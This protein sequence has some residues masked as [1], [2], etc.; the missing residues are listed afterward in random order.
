MRETLTGW[1]EGARENA[2]MVIVLGAVLAIL[3][4]CPVPL[5]AEQGEDPGKPVATGRQG[6]WSFF[7]APYGWLTGVSGTVVTDGD[8]VDIDVPFEDFLDATRAGLMLYFEARRDRFF[9][10][11]D[12]TWATLGGES[13][14]TLI[15][16]D[17]EVRQRI[18]DVRVGYEL[19]NRKLGDPIDR[20]KFDWQRRGII[21]V[22]IGGRYF[23]TEPVVT[24]SPII[25]DERRI[26]FVDSRVD[27]FLGL[28][29]GWDMSYRWLIGFRGDIGGFG[30]GD[31]ARFSWQAAAEVGFR[32]SRRVVV[33]AGYRV[34]A[35]DTIVG[36][37]TDRN[38]TDLRQEGP[39]IGGGYSF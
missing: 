32:A 33:F 39:I 20:P 19:L 29:A 27:P 7:A 8:A 17:V 13:D 11:F 22:F 34:L 12:G 18:Y 25:G 16:L 23:R 28:R 24:L 4:V 36:E 6:T 30:I 3:T 2:A 10:A 26:S 31:A 35:Y 21:D 15:D 1:D 14:G 37:G 38:G 5:G 9:V